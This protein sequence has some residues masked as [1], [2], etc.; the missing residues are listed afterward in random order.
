MGKYI[1][2]RKHSMFFFFQKCWLEVKTRIHRGLAYTRERSPCIISGNWSFVVPPYRLLVS[3]QHLSPVFFRRHEALILFHL[4]CLAYRISSDAFTPPPTY[5]HLAGRINIFISSKQD[6]VLSAR[7]FREV[8]SDFG[9]RENMVTKHRTC[10][11][12]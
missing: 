6:S 10:L 4:F 9:N 3:R 1:L 5:A 7:E 2:S 11:I 8:R 12:I